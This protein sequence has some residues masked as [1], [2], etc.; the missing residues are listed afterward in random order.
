MNRRDFIKLTAPLAVVPFFS[1]QLFAA[2]MPHTLQ[3]EALLG[4]LGPESDRVLVVIQLSGGNDGL[5]MVLPLD[6]Y[7]NLAAARAN[8]LIPDTSALVLGSSQTGLH[9][10][11]TGLKD[12]FDQQKL[13]VVQSVGYSMQN[14]S[15]FRSGDIW[16]TG[17]NS[18]DVLS[19]GWLGRYLEYAFPGFPD[20]YPNTLMPDPL[21]IRIGSGQTLGIQ[22]TE[23]STGQNIPTNFNGTLT[24]LNNLQNTSLPTGNAAIELAFLRNQQQYTNQYGTRIVNAWAAGANL[25]SY[26]TF[27]GGQNLS[28]QLK[29]VARLIKG[30]L[31]TRVYWVSMGGFDTHAT[32]VVDTDH[33]QGVHANLLKELSD[34]IA[35]FQQDLMMMG[36]E[37]RVIGLTHSEFGRRIKSNASAGTDHGA[38]APLFVFGSKVS[39]GIIGSNPIIPASASTSATVAMQFDFKAVYQSVMRYWF[40]MQDADANATLGYNVAPI[41][42]INGNCFSALPVELARFL[43]ERANEKDAQ[44]S[45][46]TASENGTESFEIERSTD[47]IHFKKVGELP[48]NGH[49]HEVQNYT[50]L[51]KNLPIDKSTIFYYRLKIK[52]LDNEFEFSDI[53]SVVFDSTKLMA[54]ISPNPSYGPIRVA[55]KGGIDLDNET[56][57][58]IHDVNGRLIAHFSEYY[59][60]TSSFELDLSDEPVGIYLISVENGD[61][62]LVKKVMVKR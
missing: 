50:F 36:L 44:I 39:G 20:A 13:A 18:T 32:Q 30:G 34:N 61:K 24:Q 54:D 5:N 62:H 41:V 46:T 4:A 8:I 10:A 23:I 2:A 25:A 60:A 47:E 51:D 28:S 35:V 43:A 38:A 58:K 27:V 7:S 9:P 37:D 48:A 52:D 33:T 15:H 40:C 19:S 14:F 53:R 17:S 55:F 16:Q 21:S 31:K 11:M 26:P 22:G 29:I 49:T 59:D 57:I 12:L 3:D 56:L 1:N 6:Q 42:P 45:W